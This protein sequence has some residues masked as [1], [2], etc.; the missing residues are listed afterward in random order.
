MKP[1]SRRTSRNAFTLIELLVVISIIALLIAILLPALGAA[2][3]SAARSQ[4][5][6][7]VRQIATATFTFSTDDKE[8]RL[9]PR[10]AGSQ[11]HWMGKAAVQRPLEPEFRPLNEYLMGTS[12]IPDNA[13]VEIAHAPLDTG[14]DGALSTYDDFGS[15]YAPNIV[16]QPS[17]VFGGSIVWGIGGGAPAFTNSD[18]HQEIPSIS[19]D[20]VPDASEMVV[21]GEFGMY[22]N[23]WSY[24]SPTEAPGYTRW[25]FGPD[26]PKWNAGFGD[27]HGSVI[28][29]KAGET[30]G[31]GFRFSWK[32][33]PPSYVQP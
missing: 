16:E 24:N 28:E 27:G 31:D 1:E 33:P 13:D 22:F 30:W 10:I 6:S 23:G 21:V 29:V 18:G 4:S 8:N 25:S 26:I 14:A 15:S 7:N 11:W 17:S 9:P 5:L 3:K 19:L 12:Q 20:L 32:D 2:R